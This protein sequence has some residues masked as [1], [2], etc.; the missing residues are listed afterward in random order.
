MLQHPPAG[1]FWR[2]IVVLNSAK[3]QKLSE[4]QS[5][6]IYWIIRQGLSLNRSGISLPIP[7]RTGKY[8]DE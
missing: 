6:S 4:T 1:S 5:T 2:T 8:L 7:K 3:L